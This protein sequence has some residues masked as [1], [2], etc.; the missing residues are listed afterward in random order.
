MVRFLRTMSILGLFIWIALGP[1]EVRA[2]SPCPLGYV[3]GNT[4][5]LINGCPVEVKLCYKCSPTALIA[6]EFT[7]F[8]WSKIDSNCIFIPPIPND[9]ILQVKLK[10]AFVTQSNGLVQF[11]TIPPCQN[12]D[13]VCSYGMKLSLYTPLCITKRRVNGEI[14]SEVCNASGYCRWN[15][16]VCH[17]QDSVIWRECKPYDKIGRENCDEEYWE[18]SLVPLDGTPTPCFKNQTPC[19]E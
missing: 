12:Q 1:K 15:V 5:L 17:T 4:T 6:A 19:N 11:C 18:D 13:S 2:Q 14:L 16:A 8:S 3:L 7:I 9:S 10:E